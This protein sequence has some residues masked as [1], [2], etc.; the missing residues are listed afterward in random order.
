MATR[1]LCNNVKVVQ[2]IVPGTYKTGADPS[3]QAVDTRGYD[4]VT[5]LLLAGDA[6]DAQTLT[7]KHSYDNSSYEDIDKA[8]VIGGEAI[9]TDFGTTGTAA[10]AVKVL[11]YKGGK[12]YLKVGSTGAGT[13]GAE[14]AVVA[15]L[16]HPKYAP[17]DRS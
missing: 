8:D 16:G 6:T 1:D 5:L 7:V 10:G 3:G 15:I 4:S 11:G 17:V 14:Y 2:A 13:T 12:R 9:L